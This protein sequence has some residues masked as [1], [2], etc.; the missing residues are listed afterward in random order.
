M[1]ARVLSLKTTGWPQTSVWPDK[2][3][4]GKGTCFSLSEVHSNEKGGKMTPV[5]I[6]IPWP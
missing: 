2:K 5:G 4:F 3:A 1:T 6:L